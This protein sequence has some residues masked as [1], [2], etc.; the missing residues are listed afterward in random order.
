MARNITPK[1]KDYSQWYLDTALAAELADYAPLI[2]R[3]VHA[4]TLKAW[5]KEQMAAGKTPPMDLF[6]AR[7]VWTTQIK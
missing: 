7:P 1:D 5:F 2:G 4:Q 3:D 6:G